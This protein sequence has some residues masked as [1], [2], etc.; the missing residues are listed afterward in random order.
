[1]KIRAAVA[2]QQPRPFEL[3]DLELDE[4]RTDEVLV[5]VVASGI[6]QTDAHVQHGRIPM[7]LPAVLGHEG[8]GIVERV[9]DGVTTLRPGDH[10]VMSYQSCGNCPS[11]LSGHPAYCDNAIAAN[12]SGA[13]LDGSS[14]YRRADGTAVG[15]HFFGQSSFATRTLATPRNLVKVPDDLPLEL[16]AP[17][18]CG[19][20][21][22]AGAV[23]NSLR[24]EPGS[25]IAVLGTGA[26]GLAAV[27]AARAAG[28][29][30]IVGVDV[31]PAR[32]A[33]AAELGAT[34][35]VNPRDA[36]VTAE[37]ARIARRGMDHVFDTT[38]RKDMLTHA[39]AA[40]APMG[41]LG[42]VAAGGPELTIETS[43][44]ALGKSVTGIVQGDAV[45]QLFIPRLIEL[46]RAGL[47]PFDRLIQLYDFADIDRA[48]ADAASGAVIKPVL[49]IAE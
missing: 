41:R 47:F 29:A 22:G 12:F 27:M 25:S 43:A 21:T 38:G 10:V 26:V 32:L 18:G 39:V 24:A 46:Y 16:L 19:L 35:T 28:A 13:R 4:P 23:I 40:L 1:V 11:C 5:R 44:L 49:R 45:P 20:Q 8:A 2:E 7:P 17:L 3:E 34:H 30:V 33:V 15:G 42:F 37:L 36:D 9:G 31:N 14:A 48:F 6:C